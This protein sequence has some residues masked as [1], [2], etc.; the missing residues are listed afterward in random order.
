MSLSLDILVVLADDP[1]LS[2]WEG[3]LDIRCLGQVRYLK[4]SEAFRL[5]S[6]LCDLFHSKQ[7]RT[8]RTKPF[9]CIVVDVWQVAVERELR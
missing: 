1:G 2:N 9:L 3:G 4:V 8:P 5:L 6:M 7:L